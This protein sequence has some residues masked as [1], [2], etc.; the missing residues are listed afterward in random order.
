METALIEAKKGV[1]KNHGGPFGAVV[2]L[3]GKIIAKAHNEVVGKKDPTLHAE[4]NAI[5]KACKKLKRFDLSD[6]ELYSTCKPCPMC[7][8]AIYWAKIKKIYFGCSED[9]AKKIGFSDKFIHEQ[10]ISKNKKIKLEQM[11]RKGCLKVFEL[12]ERKKDK[13]LY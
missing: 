2:V 8:S 10:I 12:W 7:L 9:D 1:L 11:E 5:R 6:C 3:K 13:I 4:I